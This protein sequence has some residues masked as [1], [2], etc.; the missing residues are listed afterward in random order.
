MLTWKQGDAGRAAGLIARAIEIKPDAHE[1]RNLLLVQTAPDQEDII[2]IPADAYSALRAQAEGGV[3]IMDVSA[4]ADV[5]LG[6]AEVPGDPDA[7]YTY[8]P[9]LMTDTGV[10]VLRPGKPGDLCLLFGTRGSTGV[11]AVDASTG[12]ERWRYRAPGGV[13]VYS[14]AIADGLRRAGRDR[15]SFQIVVRELP[16]RAVPGK[17][18][19]AKRDD[20]RAVP[21]CR[22]SARRRPLARP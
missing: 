18:P 9:V 20:T 17:P 2:D 21:A 1:F 12:H 16:G 15:D 22:A 5:L 7:I 19:V 6:T 14:P 13:Q 11:V 10:I 4:G 3:L 8:D